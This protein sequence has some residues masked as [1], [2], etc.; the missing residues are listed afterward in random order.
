MMKTGLADGAGRFIAMRKAPTPG[1]S[2]CPTLVLVLGLFFNHPWRDSMRKPALFKTVLCGAALTL[3]SHLAAD[4]ITDQVDIGVQAYKAGEMRQ[5]IQELQ[6]AIAQIQEQ[7]DSQYTKLMPEPLEGWS[8]QEAQS[9]SAGMSMMGGGTQVSRDYNKNG[10][11]E[12]VRIQVMAD[13]PFL[14][15]M[16]MMLSNPMMMQSDP[17]SKLYRHGRHRGMIKHQRNSNQWEISLMVA[18]RIMVQVSGNGLESEAPLEDYLKALDLA[19][20]EK[21]FSM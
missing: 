1:A 13:S 4:E 21:A 14:Q 15:A 7:L 5:A 16:S 11:N 10:G 8:A 3:A 17:S 9:Q 2:A 18:N 12:S 6:Y 20:V 19:K